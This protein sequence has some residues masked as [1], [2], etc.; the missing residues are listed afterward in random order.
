MPTMPYGAS[1]A[2]CSAP[3]LAAPY[4]ATPEWWADRVVDRQQWLAAH[5]GSVNSLVLVPVK[6]DSA[7]ASRCGPGSASSR[8]GRPWIP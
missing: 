1:S 8:T 7:P 3:M 5:S 6:L 2:A 4:T